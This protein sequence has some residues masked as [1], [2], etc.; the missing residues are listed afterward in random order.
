MLCGGN[1]GHPE[2]GAECVVN[3]FAGDNRPG[4]A[5]GKGMVLHRVRL[6]LRTLRTELDAGSLDRTSGGITT[7]AEGGADWSVRFPV[8]TFDLCGLGRDFAFFSIF[9]SPAVQDNARYKDPG[10]G[11]PGG[12]LRRAA[13]WRC[14]NGPIIFRREQVPGSGP[15]VGDSFGKGTELRDVDH[16]LSGRAEVPSPVEDG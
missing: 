9:P 1:I 12:G 15:E 6:R 4:P 2:C 10:S 11:D 16:G 3:E 8:L 13:G 5:W 7:D 14:R